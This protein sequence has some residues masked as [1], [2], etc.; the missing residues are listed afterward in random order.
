MKIKRLLLFLTLSIGLS[1]AF[2]SI[3]GFRDIKFGDD[4]EKLVSYKTSKVSKEDNFI[5]AE[6]ID[7]NLMIDDLKVSSIKYSFK[8]GELI[9]VK[10]VIEN[11]AQ[12]RSSINH[13]KNV[14]EK[15]YGTF[16]S[17]YGEVDVYR[18]ESDSSAITIMPHYTLDDVVIFIEDYSW[19]SKN[20]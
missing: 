18:L 16:K 10:I 14:F 6:K 12:N 15:K 3:S 7:E 9:A 11:G 13:I 1:F 2:E 8:Y 17:L 4:I 5:V 20:Q 19:L